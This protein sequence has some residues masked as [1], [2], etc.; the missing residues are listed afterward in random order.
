MAGCTLTSVPRVV[1][2]AG[3]AAFPGFRLRVL[4]RAP[5][6]QDVVRAAARAGAE[7]GFCCVA[8]EQTAGR[9]RQGRGWVAPPGDGLL[10]SVLVRVGAGVAAGVPL[11]AGVAVCDAVEALGVEAGVVGVKWPNDV[12]VRGSGQ[13]LAGVLAEVEPA[14][15]RSGVSPRATDIPAP[16]DFRRRAGGSPGTNP[17]A[18]PEPPGQEAP[19]PTGA[20][21]DSPSH[22]PLAIALGIGL[23]LTVDAFPTDVSGASLHTLL[24]RGVEWPEALA[25]L[26]TAL[27]ARIRELEGGGLPATLATWRAHALGLG[28][29]I[30]AHTPSGV[31]HGI[32]RDIAPDGA[33]L[34]DTPTGLARLLAGDVHLL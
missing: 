6:T 23:N 31:I 24:G 22:E 21:P 18:A 9:G 7:A 16:P 2:E 25:A 4:E 8:R 27:G 34:V 1:D 28:S 33:L 32:A 12:L 19:R 17:Q 15:R 13:K 14:A 20:P 10:M 3:R 29:P 5:S 11:L 30:E 26:L